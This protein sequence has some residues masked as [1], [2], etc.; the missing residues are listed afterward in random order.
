MKTFD[1]G[2]FNQTAT[3]FA[4]ALGIV[5]TIS[6]FDAI[7]GAGISAGLWTNF[8]NEQAVNDFWQLGLAAI[9]LGILYLA[10][11]KSLDVGVAAG[12]ML[13]AYTE[14]TL[15]YSLL[16]LTKP[17][18]FWLSNGILIVKTGFPSHIGGWIGWISRFFQIVPSVEISLPAVILLNIF[19]AITVWWLL[20][21][22]NNKE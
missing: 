2:R 11:K 20:Y 8:K 17:I 15:Y 3:E 5:L 1:S 7:I 6:F 14:D 12:L 10:G 21:V 22:E 16:W 18:V 9:S 4:K 19:G 13:A